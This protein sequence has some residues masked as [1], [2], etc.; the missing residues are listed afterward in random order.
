[1]FMEVIISVIL[2]IVGIAILIVIHVCVVGRA[3][4]GRTAD[5]IDGTTS[6]P[7][8]ARPDRV[9]RMD[10]EDIQGLPCFDYKI[11][12]IVTGTGN[13]NRECA[14]CLESFRGGEKCRILPKCGHCF[15][16]EC[17][18][19]WLLKTA[20]CPVCRTGA[21]SPQLDRNRRSYSGDRAGLE[22]V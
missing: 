5:S 3:F 10:P 17:I 13:G 4:R 9:P 6:N 2:L 12:E 14:V 15:H 20:A 7:I 8:Q 22:L 16:A 19:S 11:E 21:K 18:D 1:M